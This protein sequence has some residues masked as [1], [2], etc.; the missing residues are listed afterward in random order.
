MA[1]QAQASELAGFPKPQEGTFVWTEIA[2]N[3]GDAEKCKAFYAAVFGW[4]FKDSNAAEGMPY[5][6][7]ST[8]GDNPAGGLY[9]IDPKFFEG[10]PQLPPPHFLPYIA[11]D[12]IDANAKKAEE[13]GATI[14]KGPMDIPNVGRFAVI[15]D[16]AGAVFAT[17]SMGK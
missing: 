14:L 1:E 12:D 11:V 3:K 5:H 6:E 10:Q 8:G 4:K 7:F 16:P 13:L 9:E 15:K 17:F 2:V